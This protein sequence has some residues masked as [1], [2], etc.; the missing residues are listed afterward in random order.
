MREAL[1]TLAKSATGGEIGAEDL[2]WHALRYRHTAS[3][4]SAAHRA[5]GAMGDPYPPR[6]GDPR[7]SAAPSARSLSVME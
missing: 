4:R 2:P 5:V 7:Y 3:M 1:E 6:F